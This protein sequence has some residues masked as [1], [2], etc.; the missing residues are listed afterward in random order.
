MG[1]LEEQTRGD[2]KGHETLKS[3]Q[4]KERQGERQN[5]TSSAFTAVIY[6]R[7]VEVD[8]GGGLGGGRRGWAGVRG[9]SIMCNNKKS[10]QQSAFNLLTMQQTGPD[11]KRLPEE[12][13]S[14]SSHVRLPVTQLNL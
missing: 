4:I 5:Q 12:R 13:G 1:G 2:N 6:E 10:S 7:A 11:V 3:K 8:V 14:Q 9:R